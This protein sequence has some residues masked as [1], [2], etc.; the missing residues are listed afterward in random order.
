MKT[1]TFL[2]RSTPECPELGYGDTVTVTSTEKAEKSVLYS[3]AAST[4]PNPY[5]LDG[6]KIIPW[7]QIYAMVAPG[8][9]EFECV[10]HIK[11]G[12][13]LLINSGNEVPT[14]NR[15]PN[16]NGKKI[17]T[18]I[19]VHKGALGSKN[20]NWRGSRACIT[21]PPDDCA[22]FFAKFVEGEGGKIILT[23]TGSEK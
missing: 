1:V 18:E 7:Q 21:I 10:L 20:K 9:Y 19:F 15:N 8:E 11:F 13:S 23:S 4:C 14:I 5:R 22:A 16:H 12:K 2:R 3:G 6:T 17:A